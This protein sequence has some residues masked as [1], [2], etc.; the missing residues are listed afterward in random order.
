MTTKIRTG[1]NIKQDL[2]EL[3]QNALRKGEMKNDRTTSSY[4]KTSSSAYLMDEKQEQPGIER[5]HALA[6]ISRSALCCAGNETRAPIANPLN[7]AHN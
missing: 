6:D 2:K 5:V 3:Q 7:S 4:R 1:I